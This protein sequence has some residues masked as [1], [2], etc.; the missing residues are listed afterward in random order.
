MKIKKITATDIPPVKNFMADGLKDL[1]VIAGPNGV[2]KTR[3]VDAMLRYFKTP[4]SNNRGKYSTNPS[5]IIEAT[6]AF[7]RE[8]WGQQEL[9]TTKPEEAEA[10]QSFL[11]GRRSRRNLRNSV[12]NY[13]SN[14]WVRQEN[15][16]AS[17]HYR[18]DPWEEDIPSK[19]HIGG[20]R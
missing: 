20:T 8:T 4:S 17:K 2:G 9:D 14:R 12:L 5:F 1:V 18:H 10:L 6:D 19:T 16:S 3:L 7:E 11:Q 15:S 13:E